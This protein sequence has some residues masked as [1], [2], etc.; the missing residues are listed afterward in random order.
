S[1]KPSASAKPS[2]SVKPSASAT[3]TPSASGMPSATPSEA[4]GAEIP[5]NTIEDLQKIGMAEYPLNASY[6]LMQDIDAG[7][8]EISPIGT[9]EAPFSGTFNGNGKRISHLKIASNQEDSGLFGVLSGSVFGLSLD[10]ITIN[11][12]S[13]INKNIGTLAGR[14]TGQ[15][16]VSDVFVSGEIL[17]ENEN[18]VCGGLAGEIES[19]KS[20]V[21]VQAY[22]SIAQNGKLI[23]AF[24]GKNSA[25]AAIFK[26][27][28]WS[29]AYLKDRAFGVDSP[30][31]EAEGLQKI[32]TNPTYLALMAGGESAE[33]TADS[34]L[35][36]AYGLTFVRWEST[37]LLS[38]LSKGQT[39]TVTSGQESGAQHVYAVYERANADGTKTEVKF[40]T[41]VI[42]SKDIS[43][44]KPLE[45]IDKVFPTQIEKV[46]P[47]QPIDSIFPSKLD[48]DS[49][50]VITQNPQNVDGQEGQSVTFHVIAEGKNLTYQWQEST[51]GLTW[52][53]IE[54]A[55][56][57]DYTRVVT[58]EDDKKQ[59][60]CGIGIENAPSA[61]AQPTPSAQTTPSTTPS[62]SA[63][64]TPST[65]P[66][67][68][69]QPTPSTTP[70]ASVQPTPTADGTNRNKTS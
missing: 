14:I 55:T 44:T 70:S 48:T 60:R 32:Q 16:S 50:I 36:Q 29:S 56:Q 26:D 43:E 33:V 62:A 11:K 28:I 5:I 63:Q 58:I 24:A 27:N 61:S 69:V 39:V 35:S 18:A 42:I 20:I 7:G 30:L 40:C 67:A 4:Q 47:L 64:P 65:T 46:V 37:E 52:T 10:D 59:F 41:P 19:A 17:C 53:D 38:I 68:S 45:P 49:E 51:D 31:N 3:S 13:N 57:K 54:G 9:S 2:A 34:A 6:L 12:N 8:K 66:S 25:A 15:A 21:R 1:V 22:V 23:G